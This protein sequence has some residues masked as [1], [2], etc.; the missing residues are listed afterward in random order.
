VWCGGGA[1]SAAAKWAA[2]GGRWRGGRGGAWGWRSQT[3]FVCM[4][5]HVHVSAKKAAAKVEITATSGAENPARVKSPVTSAATSGDV[6][7]PLSNMEGA[8]NA[9]T[10][11]AATSARSMRGVTCR[12]RGRLPTFGPPKASKN[13][14]MPTSIG[15]FFQPARSTKLSSP[16]HEALAWR[17]SLDKWVISGEYQVFGEYRLRSEDRSGAGDRRAMVQDCAR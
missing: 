14:T 6:V 11:D 13:G 16:L 15:G 17:S 8:A 4:V 2:G 7:L 10:A 9:E 5:V 1:V 12:S 3:L